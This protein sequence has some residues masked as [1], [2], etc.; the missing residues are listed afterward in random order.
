MSTVRGIELS[1]PAHE[2]EV[3][4]SVALPTPLVIRVTL[5]PD[6]AHPEAFT[7]I[8]VVS[9]VPPLVVSEGENVSEPVTEVHVTPPVATVTVA[10]GALGLELHAPASRAIRPSMSTGTDRGLH[11]MDMARPPDRPIR[12]SRRASGG[13]SGPER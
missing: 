5:D 11:D 9:A 1:R 12:R 10:T 4:V 13:A 7:V 2:F 8:D 6:V 3:L